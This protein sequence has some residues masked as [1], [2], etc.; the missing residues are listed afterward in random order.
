[1]EMGWVLLLVGALFLLIEVV[2]PGFF[3]VVPGTILL[4]IGGLMILIPD[5]LSYPWSPFLFA[6][7][8]MVVSVATIAFYRRL[9]PGQKPLT[10]SMDSLA[11]KVG[12][13]VNDIVPDTIDGKVKIDSQVWSAT[14]DESIRKGEKVAV[15]RVSGVH[16]FV[17]RVS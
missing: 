13:V 15:V 4:I 17:K 7:I 3:A 1:M 8:T 2:L 5:L 14:S 9:A 11:G 16:L 6:I 12:E 10:T